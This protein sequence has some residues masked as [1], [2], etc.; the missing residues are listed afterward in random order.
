MK[1]LLP[2]LLLAWLLASCQKAVRPGPPN[3]ILILADDLGWGD[4]GCYGQQ[5]I[6]TPRLDRMAAEGLRFTNFYAASPVCAPSRGALLTGLHT[7][8]AFLRDNDEMSE[9]GDV[10][11]D[12]ALE[13]QRP[14]PD[15][16]ITAAELLRAQGYASACIGKWGLGWSG[17]EGDPV[18]QGFDHFFGYLCQRQAHDYYPDHLW[19]N[20]DKVPLRNAGGVDVEYSH[21]LITQEALEWVRTNAARPFFLMWTPTI[22]HLALQVPEDGL[23]EYADAFPE[24]PY[25][26]QSGYRPHATPRAAYASMVSRLDRDVGLL[27]DLLAELDL[28]ENTLVIFTSDNGASW[29]GG[30]DLEFFQNNGPLRGRKAQLWEGGIRVPMIAWGPGRVAPG[31]VSDQPGA[32]WD[33]VSTFCQAAGAPL[34]ASGD[35]ISLLPLLEGR[36]AS[37]A[38]R[39]PLY[40]E[41]QGAQALREDAWKLLRPRPGAAPLLFDLA[42][43]P[44]E[45]QD[46]AASQPE[47]VAKMLELMERQRTESALFPLDPR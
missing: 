39:S 41:F 33:L 29:L 10:W 30:C 36:A 34:P 40:W 21:D 27:L 20:A 8:H 25:D 31:R 2:L 11:K 37:L 28:A 44:G 35:G 38:T 3:V 42:Q 26:G 14:L 9:R 12:P 24:Q 7:G 6:R 17:S 32:S 19:R 18:R 45:T 5:K 13:G 1:H 16:E 15:A 43:D 22:P 46:L 47:R 4:L 23:A